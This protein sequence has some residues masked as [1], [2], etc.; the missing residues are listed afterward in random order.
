MDMVGRKRSRYEAFEA[1][2]DQ[3]QVQYVER[4]TCNMRLAGSSV[5][6]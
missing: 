5:A 3:L 1:D 4:L 2:A 6:V